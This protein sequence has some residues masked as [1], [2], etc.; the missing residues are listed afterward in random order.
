MTLTPLFPI[1]LIGLLHWL[2]PS[3]VPPTL[4]FGVRIPRDRADAP[5][6]AVWRRRY[7]Y[8]TALV[9]IAVVAGMLGLHDHVWVGPVAVGANLLA[10]MVL[11]LV[12]RRP[13]PIAGS[14][15]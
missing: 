10:G 2:V 14:P 8:G 6:I 3:F 11:Y 4:P 13:S 12:A 7:R 1:V 9:T 15:R 5:V